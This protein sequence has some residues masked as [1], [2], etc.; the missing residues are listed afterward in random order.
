MTLLVRDEQDIIKENIEFHLAQGVDF[1]IVTDNKSIDATY[2][3]LADYIKQGLVHYIFEDEDNYNQHQWVTRMAR[4]AFIDFSADW[5][6]NNDA[7]EFWWP[8]EDS[9]LDTFKNVPNNFNIIEAKRYN[10]I[11]LNNELY[12]CFYK[13]MVYREVVS[14]NPL[15]NPLPPKVA[16]IGSKDIIVKQGNHRVSGLSDANTLYEV[17][18]ILH[19]PLR[20]YQQFLNKITKGGAA[21]ERNKELPK[22]VGSTWRR[23]YEEYQLNNNLIEYYKT[24]SYSESK[25]QQGL[26]EKVI[27]KDTR[28]LDFFAHR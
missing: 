5:V 15:G 20:T 21:Y 25:I 14:L 8:K 11:P 12:P 13:N 9:L 22:G 1:F 27:V 17:I 3:I 7:D 6:I 4:M 26:E 10:F 16:H 28:L 2:E 23:L 24:H 18:D 19:Y